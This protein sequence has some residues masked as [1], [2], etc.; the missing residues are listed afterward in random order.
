M[1]PRVPWMEQEGPE[2]WDRETQSAKGDTQTSGMCLQNVRG[3]Y[4]QSDAGSHTFQSIYGCEVES[5][6]LFLRGF[7]QYAYDGADYIALNEDLSSWTAADTAAQITQHKWEADKYADGF[8]AYLEGR[9]PESLRRYLENRKEA[10]KRSGT[11]GC[12][13]SPNSL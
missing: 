6:G 13:A 12:G 8:R 1:E 10:L 2:Y 9:C 7:A 4:N 3:Y 11:R 5:E